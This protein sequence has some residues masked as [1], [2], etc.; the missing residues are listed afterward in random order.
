M[1]C[2]HKQRLGTGC[3]DCEKEIWARGREAKYARIWA[4]AYLTALND[5]KFGK[6]TANPF[7]ENEQ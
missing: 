2:E 1:L 4:E 3:K 5:V 6:V 7:Q